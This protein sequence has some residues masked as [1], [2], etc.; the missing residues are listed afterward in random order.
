[1]ILLIIENEMTP[2]V[3]A[4]F[5]RGTP[6]AVNHERCNVLEQVLIPLLFHLPLRNERWKLFVGTVD[7]SIFIRCKISGSWSSSRTRD[8]IWVTLVWMPR[9]HLQT[10]PVDCTSS[11]LYG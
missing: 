8:R 9:N 1:M 3:A 7:N 10:L 2:S 5:P 4:M 11:I 6:F